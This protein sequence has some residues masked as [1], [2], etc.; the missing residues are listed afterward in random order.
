MALDQQDN[1]YLHNFHNI[2]A[3]NDRLCQQA[4]QHGI[5]VVTN[6]HELAEAVSQ[7]QTLVLSKFKGEGI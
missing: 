5:P 1:K 6:D 7:L 2:R 4:A 3:I